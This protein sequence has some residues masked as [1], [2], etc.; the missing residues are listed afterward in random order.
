MDTQGPNESGPAEKKTNP[1]PG[2]GALLAPDLLAAKQ[3]AIQALATLR[4]ACAEEQ[5]RQRAWVEAKLKKMEASVREREEEAMSARVHAE[6]MTVMA[7]LRLDEYQA[8]ERAITELEA[9]LA[10]AV[11]VV[12]KVAAPVPTLSAFQ[13]R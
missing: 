11:H 2:M 6:K 13:A 8:V 3:R 1:G 5:A 9:K 10:L 7:D 12:D 4:A